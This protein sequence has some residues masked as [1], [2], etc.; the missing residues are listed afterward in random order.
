MNDV[1][2][3]STWSVW[4]DLLA[5]AA[6]NCRA[7]A[8]ALRY[9]EDFLSTSEESII[10]Q[11]LGFLQQIYDALNDSDGVAGVAAIRASESSLQ[12]QI[13]QYESTGIAD[14]HCCSVCVHA[15][16]FIPGAF[17]DAADCYTKAIQQDPASLEF[18]EVQH[19]C[20]MTSD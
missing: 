11:K 18:H 19:T 2:V 4:Q 17:H 8:R 15:V 13:L 3:V 20:T 7:Y 5:R 1:T 16:L 9:L 14:R 12:E 10:Q 6:F